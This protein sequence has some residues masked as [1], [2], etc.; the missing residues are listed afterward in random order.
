MHETAIAEGLVGELLR[1]RAEGTWSGRLVRVRLRVGK[2]TAVVPEALSFC[3]D[4]I[5][6][7]GDLEG[8]ALDLEEVPVR[9]LCLDCGSASE[10]EA[11]GFLCASCGSPRVQ[12][13]AG[14]ELLIDSLEVCDDVS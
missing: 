4:A 7:G 9:G 13:T 12:I 5:V 8:I 2:L 6:Q 1:L 10:F 3:F 14:R 11:L